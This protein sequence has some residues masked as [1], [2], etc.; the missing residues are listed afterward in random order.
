MYALNIFSGSSGELLREKEKKDLRKEKPGRINP[1]DEPTTITSLFFQE[2][3]K[4]KQPHSYLSERL[5]RYKAVM[6]PH[7]GTIQVTQGEEMFKCRNANCNKVSQFRVKGQWHVK[8]YDFP[9][10]E[11]ACRWAKKWIEE[12]YRKEEGKKRKKKEKKTRK[13]RGKRERKR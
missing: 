13:K 5:F 7:C 10:H 1:N 8:L 2:R 6:C 12:E 11:E 4:P 9:S 3:E